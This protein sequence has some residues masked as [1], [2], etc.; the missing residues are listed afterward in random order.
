MGHES[1]W[2]GRR[3]RWRS[4][5]EEARHAQ[6]HADSLACEAW[7]ARMHL[8]GGPVQPSP[9]LRGAI[10]GGFPFLRVQC[11]ACQQNAWVDLSQVRRAQS[12]WIWQLEASLVC[13]HCRRGTRFA[14]R[15]RIERLCRA[16]GE[17][18]EAP[19]QDRG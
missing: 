7:N 6:Q 15:A 14:P 11:N 19:F 3:S 18:G 16:H 4:K 9:S 12:T 13:Q 1:S 5:D 10:D 17:M 8:L 2:S